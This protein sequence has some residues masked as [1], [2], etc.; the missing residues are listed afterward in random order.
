M[1]ESLKTEFEFLIKKLFE[2]EARR[3]QQQ[4]NQ[5][6][7]END[8]L[9]GRYT[10]GFNYLGE[11]YGRD[12][13]I[14]GPTTTEVLSPLLAPRMVKLLQFCKNVEFDKQLIT[15]IFVKL[16]QPC[17]SME[18]LR[19]TLPECVVSLD[20]YLPAMQRIREP[21]WSI[22]NNPRDL[23]QY[24]KVLPRI[25]TYCAMRFLY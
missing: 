21:A 4:V 16:I 8:K 25:E 6:I 19:D 9:L 20:S 12:G 11:N 15:Q 2:P 5:L 24:E 7:E 10:Q 22:A 23:R 3:H 17:Q 1:M 13:A 14:V 18:D